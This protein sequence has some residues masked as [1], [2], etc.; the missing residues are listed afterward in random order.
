MASGDELSVDDLASL[1]KLLWEDHV[2]VKVL[3]PDKN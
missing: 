2:Y 3:I 1:T